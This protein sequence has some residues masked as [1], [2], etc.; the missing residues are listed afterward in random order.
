LKAAPKTRRFPLIVMLRK[1]CLPPSE[2]HLISAPENR[3]PPHHAASRRSAQAG[4]S[5]VVW[6][7]SKVSS[8]FGGIDLHT[9]WI[10]I[11]K[12]GHSHRT[13]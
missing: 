10:G 3:G 12:P 1:G 5:S 2:L 6:A 7:S 8:P 11:S 9:D 4:A 13:R